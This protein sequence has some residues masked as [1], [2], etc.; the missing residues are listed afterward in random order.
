MA[1]VASPPPAPSA[2]CGFVGNLGVVELRRTAVEHRRQTVVAL[3]S[4]RAR[5]LC[6]EKEKHPKII[7]G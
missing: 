4:L 3:P 1:A 7:R 6:A 2:R 5:G